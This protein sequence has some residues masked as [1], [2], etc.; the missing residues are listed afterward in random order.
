[1]FTAI[2][3]AI[4]GVFGGLG[5]IFDFMSKKDT[6]NQIRKG[7]EEEKKADNLEE[8]KIGKEKA[9]KA[10]AQVSKAKEDVKAVRDADMKDAELT[11]EEVKAE[12]VEIEDED[13][14]RIR[15]IQIKAAV[16]LKKRKTIA[17]E[18]VEKNK[19]FN[20]GEEITF[21]G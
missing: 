16:E 5:S 6:E 9:D 3:E 14:K 17:V 21:G 20:D 4:G 11:D 1:M 8:D 7:Y 12:L 19:D 2:M 15:A 10:K 13:D 18:K